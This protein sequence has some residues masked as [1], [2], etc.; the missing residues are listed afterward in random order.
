M[1]FKPSRIK[2]FVIE[3]EG[4][5]MSSLIRCNL[6]TMESVTPITIPLYSD[7]F[8][9]CHKSTTYIILL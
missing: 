1:I 8:L 2:K 7:L 3:D 9:S 4:K 5:Y 6:N